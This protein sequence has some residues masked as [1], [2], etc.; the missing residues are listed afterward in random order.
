MSFEFLKNFS[1]LVLFFFLGCSPNE[2]NININDT[3]KYIIEKDI[4][5]ASP[6]GFDLTLDIYSP[7]KKEEAVPVLIIFHGG[8]WL[9]NN[10][11]IMDQMAQYLATNSNYVICNVNYRLLADL[12]NSV[13]LNEIIEDAFGALLWIKENIANYGGDKNRIAVTG[14]SAGAHIAAMIVNSGKQIN[15]KN[16][17]PKSLKFTPTYMP[18]DKSIEE[19]NLQ[20]LMSVQASILSYGAFDIYSSAIY[21][22]ETSNNPF[23][24]FSGTSPRGVFGEG[25]TYFTHPEMYKAL[26]PVFNIPSSEE[27]V[28]PPQFLLVGSKDKL[29]TPEFVLDYKKELESEGH[30]V[31]F[32]IYQDKGHAFLD[33]GTNYFLGNSFEK[34]APE[35]LNRMIKFL[36][37]VF[38]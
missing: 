7:S 26:S 30:P 8:G 25:Y 11:S 16:N 33:S 31:D 36:D 38:R 35:A 20:N 27:R 19:I 14:D 32:W 3:T 4:V 37:K 22:L 5:W 6:K 10:K 34:D 15:N 12:D 2:D 9:V 13:T 29:T 23:W 18:E 28:L 24:F 17:F 21:G 1:I